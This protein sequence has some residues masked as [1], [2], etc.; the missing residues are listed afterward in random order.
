MA[1]ALPARA[2]LDWLRKTAKQHLRTMRLQRREAKLAEA[3]FAVARQ[4]GF[5]SWRKLKSHVDSLRISNGSARLPTDETV[6]SFLRAVGDGRLNDVQAALAG[7]PRL[8]NAIGPHPYWGG[9]PQALHVSIETKRRDMF[10]LLIA[11]GADINGVNDQCEHWSPLMLTFHW[12]QPD[13]RQILMERGARVGLVEAMLLEDDAAVEKM[14]RHGESAL[15]KIEPNGGSLLAFARTPFA[16]DRLLELGVASDKK[17][18]WGTSPMEAM[19]RLGPRGRRL[20]HHLLSRGLRAEP[21]EYARLGDKDAL[22]ALI[23]ANADIARSDAV[24][25]AAVDFGHHDLVLWLIER[26]ANVNAPAAAGSG[27]TPLHSAAWNGDLPMVKLLVAAGAN[28]SARDPEHNNTPAG[29]AQVAITV[30]N[31]PRCKDVVDYLFARS[32]TAEA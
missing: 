19:S 1:N 21:Q 31:N 16:I 24:M 23:E 7:E 4:Y 11:A 2:N 29:W 26:G 5:A 6:A 8:V 32:K 12:D 28:V 10:D 17:D 9:R 14:L 3:Q 15:P 22:A 30:S 20:V 27:A 18:R 13:M 25:M